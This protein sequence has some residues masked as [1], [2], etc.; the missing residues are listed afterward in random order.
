MFSFA[1]FPELLSKFNIMPALPMRSR[2]FLDK[3]NIEQPAWW[4]NPIPTLKVSAN[5]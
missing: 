2:L 5:L 1:F 3:I 4:A